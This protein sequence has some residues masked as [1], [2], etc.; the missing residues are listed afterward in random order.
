MD[1]SKKL[2]S[3]DI[4]SKKYNQEIFHTKPKD[5]LDYYM[6]TDSYSHKSIPE[7]DIQQQPICNDD[8]CYIPNKKVEPQLIN[9]EE[10]N[11]NKPDIDIPIYEGTPLPIYESNIDKANNNDQD[12]ND[13]KVDTDII[14]KV[15]NNKYNDDKKDDNEEDTD[16][17]DKID[18]IDDIPLISPD[19]I[20][21]TKNK[22][23]SSFIEESEEETKLVSPQKCITIDNNKNKNEIEID[24][25]NMI[26]GNKLYP[27]QVNNNEKDIEDDITDAEY[28]YVKDDNKQENETISVSNILDNNSEDIDLTESVKKIINND[29]Q[30]NKDE[31]NI[32]IEQFEEQIVQANIQ[33]NIQKDINEEVTKEDI[34]ND[35]KDKVSIKSKDK[36]GRPPKKTKLKITTEIGGG[37]QEEDNEIVS[38]IESI[39]RDSRTR[40]H[41]ESIAVKDDES[42]DGSINVSDI[43]EG[44]IDPEKNYTIYQL[45]QICKSL[46]LPLSYKHKG[47]RKTYKKKELYKNIKKYVKDQNN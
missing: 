24:I 22:L 38:I 18:D 5:K 23:S 15:D 46:R 27:N 45:K 16:I 41:I 47:K 32:T 6:S 13:P 36:R 42:S 4:N 28:L 33:D 35:V 25:Y 14:D 19:N 9:K 26:S 34:N 1:N 2:S 7:E 10:T 40:D 20:R 3:I 43:L 44:N 39:T 31:D 12:N 8:V 17:I 11:N 29:I 37:T 30:D 21:T